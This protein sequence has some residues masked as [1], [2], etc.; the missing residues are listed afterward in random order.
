MM[1]I[2]R[3]RARNKAEQI[4][5]TEHARRRLAERGISVNDIIHCIDTGEIIK[6]Y[7]KMT[8]HSPA[9]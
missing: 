1:D 3:L 5:I 6:Q 7:V 2:K 8:N 9:V 4:A